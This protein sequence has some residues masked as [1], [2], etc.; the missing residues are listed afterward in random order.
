MWGLGVGGWGLR[1]GLGGGGWGFG[2]GVGL[3]PGLTWTSS[4]L[5]ELTCVFR[6]C[7]EDHVGGVRP[8]FLF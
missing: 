1:V 7:G 8:E 4:L 5:A 3:G 2:G 6:T